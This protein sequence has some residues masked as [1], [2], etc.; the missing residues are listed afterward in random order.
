VGRARTYSLLT[1]G[2]ELDVLPTAQRYGMDLST[3]EPAIAFVVNHLGVTS[4]R[5]R[6][7]SSKAGCPLP[8]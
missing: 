5:G 3:I 2:I 1:R 6:W 8:T 4:A 7:S